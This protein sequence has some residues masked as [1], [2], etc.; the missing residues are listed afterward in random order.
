MS[1]ETVNR[2]LT[3]PQDASHDPFPA[4]AVTKAELA[5]VDTK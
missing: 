1:P 4:D 2:D 5:G 3:A